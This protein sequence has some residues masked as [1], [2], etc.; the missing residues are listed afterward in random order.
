V[1]HILT[2]AKLEPHRL[3]SCLDSNDPGFEQ[4]S[5]YQAVSEAPQNAAVFCVD[6]KT[7]I[8]ALDRLDPLL[9][10]SP[11]RAERHG[12]EYCRHDN[13][14]AIRGLECEDR[15]GRW[16]NRAPAQQRGVYRIPDRAD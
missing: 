2:Q 10:L 4:S 11:G 6:E 16:K 14:V 12:F 8:Q 15:N 7:A 5:R 13:L 3:K 1:Q 9:P